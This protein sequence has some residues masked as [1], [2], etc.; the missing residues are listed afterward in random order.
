MLHLYYLI[1]SRACITVHR[2]NMN[3]AF[4][5]PLPFPSSQFQPQEGYFERWLGQEQILSHCI[6]WLIQLFEH[7]ANGHNLQK[8]NLQ[9]WMINCQVEGFSCKSSWLF[10]HQTQNRQ[11]TAEPHQQDT[12]K[13]DAVNGTGCN[14]TWNKLY[15]NSNSIKSLFKYKHPTC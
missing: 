2:V 9:V 11:A 7:V 3:L 1:D 10:L 6:C 8:W 15:L 13:K 5:F 4:P 14:L 12:Q